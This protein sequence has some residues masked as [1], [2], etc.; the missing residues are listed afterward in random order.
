MLHLQ[1]FFPAQI[2]CLLATLPTFT[3]L[4][5]S[6]ARIEE[7]ISEYNFFLGSVSSDRPLFRPDHASLQKSVIECIKLID[8]PLINFCAFSARI[9][10]LECLEDVPL[11]S[12]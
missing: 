12:E 6:F 1:T 2:F 3:L 9:E 5:R 7:G 10:V 4:R 8:E 11:I